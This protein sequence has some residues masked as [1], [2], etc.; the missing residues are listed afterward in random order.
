MKRLTALLLAAVLC[1]GAAV[2]GINRTLIAAQSLLTT[3]TTVQQYQSAKKKFQAAKSDPGYVASEHDR[4]INAGIAKCNSAINSASKNENSKPRANSNNNSSGKRNSTPTTSSVN[5]EIVGLMIANLDDNND[6]I[7][8]VNDDLYSSSINK[9][10]I[11]CRITPVKKTVTKTLRVKLIKPDGTVY[12]EMGKTAPAGY[13][14]EEKVT[15]KPDEEILMPERIYGR[16]RVGD[17]SA[18]TY[19][20]EAYLDGKKVYTTSFDIYAGTGGNAPSNDYTNNNSG[21][22]ANT[23]SSAS[24]TILESRIG[25][26]EHEG[27]NCFAVSMDVNVDGCKGRLIKA[28]AIVKDENAYYRYNDHVVGAMDQSIPEYDSTKFTNINLYI[29]TS[30]LGK[31]RNG[32]MVVELSIDDESGNTLAKKDLRYAFDGSRCGFLD[33]INF[34]DDVQYEGEQ[35]LKAHIG[36]TVQNCK[37][38]KVNCYLFALNADGTSARVDDLPVADLMTSECD[39]NITTF[40]QIELYI[41]YSKLSAAGLTG[42]NVTFRVIVDDD[43]TSNDIFIEEPKYYVGGSG[44]G[45]T[46]SGGELAANISRANLKQNTTANGEDCAVLS[47]DFNVINGAGKRIGVF[48]WIYDED[49]NNPKKVSDPESSMLYARTAEPTSNNVSY[50]DA[51]I[52]IPTVDLKPYRGRTLTLRIEIDN[53]ADGTTILEENYTFTVE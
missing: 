41:P 16:G 2:A 27:E 13:S 29:P 49:G 30:K 53:R 17:F 50:T 48:A 40:S 37:G 9:L 11:A 12:R 51:E 4:S 6:F 52:Y 31:F 20:Y 19:T 34:T 38:R 28:Y 39:Y 10:Y 32:T 43:E 44:S 25:V 46:S 47:V 33:F 36:Y 8:E 26:V 23:S 35:C 1:I 5:V 21:N 42:R 24:A 22:Y 7:G 14:S 3:A 18:G 45:S 15:I